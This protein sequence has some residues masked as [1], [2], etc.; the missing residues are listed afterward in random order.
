VNLGLPNVNGQDRS[1]HVTPCGGPWWAGA[2]ARKTYTIRRAFLIRVRQARVHLLQLPLSA[3]RHLERRF[4][5]IFTRSHERQKN[6]G[7]T[8]KKQKRRL[9][10]NRV[11]TGKIRMYHPPSNITKT[12]VMQ[13][14]WYNRTFDLRLEKSSRAESHL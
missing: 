9:S 6:Q 14:T 13:V 12:K 3:S 5:S 2:G 11:P 10:R 4:F 8:S 1:D 7:R